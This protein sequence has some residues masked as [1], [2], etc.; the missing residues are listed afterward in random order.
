MLSGFPHQK[1]GGTPVG[2]MPQAAAP[3][4]AQGPYSGSLKAATAPVYGVG[5]YNWRLALASAPTV[6]V[7]TAQ[8]MGGRVDLTGLTVPA[9]YN[10]AV[11]AVGA[12]GPGD[13]SEV[14]TATI[15]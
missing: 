5:A 11:Q 8:T 10:V 15:I 6:Y 13:W 12:E 3:K 1:T 2:P 7:Q 9:A 4:V 14:G